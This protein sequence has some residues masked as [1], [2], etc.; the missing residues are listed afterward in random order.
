MSRRV[1][2]YILCILLGYSIFASYALSLRLEFCFPEEVYW[3]SFMFVSIP[4]LYEVTLW[5]S[6]SKL[7]LL[8]L[9]S[10]SLMIHLQYAVTDISPLLSSEDA[11]ADYRLTNKIMADSKWTPLEPVEWGFGSEYRFYPI[12]NFLYATM[13]LLTDIPLLVVVK[14][15]FVVKALVVTPLVERLLRRF[16]N[17]RVAYLATMVFLASPGAILFPHKESFALIFFFLGMY[18]ITKAEKTRQYL[19]I[20]LISILT[21]IM[22]HHFSTYIFLGILSSLFLASYFHKGQKVVRTSS[23]FFLFCLVIFV[24]WLAFIA[25]AIVVMHQRVLFDILFKFLLPGH[26]TPSEVLPLYTVYERIIVSLGLGI[27]AVS[28]V[29]GFLG[30]M[31]NGKS[32][33]SSFLAVTVFLI[34]LLAVASVFRF[35]PHRMNVLISHRVFEFGYIVIGAFSAVFF[36]WAFKSREKLSSNVIL[37][38]AIVV[39][40]ITGPMTGAMHPR[41]FR[42]VS[43]VV[44]F[45]AISLNIWMSESNATDE[46]TVGDQLLYFILSIYGESRVA[47]YPE[48]FAS[49]YFSLPSTVRWEWSYVATYVYMTDFYGSNATRFAGSPYFH[50]LYT[51][52]LLRVYGISNRTSP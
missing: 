32:L 48:F 37:T 29:L 40:I 7:R 15:L 41:T 6:S 23:Q 39:M 9:L 52:G 24:A 1:A 45:K 30:Y 51:N 26:V 34:P 47:R 4:L 25:W 27:T 14:Y 28:A 42:R 12:T 33:S 16:F 13:S 18:A 44:S 3:L 22:T 50:S 20:G 46:Y 31:R 2:L 10:F 38:C 11:V 19:L 8:C 35:S 49:Q 36:V 5:K 43:D 21:L 17:Q